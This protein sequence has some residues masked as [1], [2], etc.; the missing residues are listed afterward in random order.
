MKMKASI[1]LFR[2]T[3]VLVFVGFLSQALAQ[4]DDW[5]HSGSMYLVTTSAGA[6]LPASAERRKGEQMRNPV[7]IN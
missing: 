4:Y 2:L 5:K 6:D 7:W 1:Y 3:L